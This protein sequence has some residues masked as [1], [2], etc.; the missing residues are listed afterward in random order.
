M[1]TYL[2]IFGEGSASHDSTRAGVEGGALHNVL[3]QVGNRGSCMKDIT[4]SSLSSN[5]CSSRLPHVHEW[6]IITEHHS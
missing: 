4:A 1:K 3:P 5:A 6:S 2:K